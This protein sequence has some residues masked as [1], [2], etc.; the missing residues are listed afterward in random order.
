MISMNENSLSF[1]IE[2][3]IFHYIMN[4]SRTIFNNSNADLFFI[5]IINFNN[6]NDFDR[7]EWATDL[8]RERLRG[9]QRYAI[10]FNGENMNLV[11]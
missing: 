11:F 10:V 1:R 3:T 7:Y 2:L 4:E 8:R 9:I 6:E 5:F